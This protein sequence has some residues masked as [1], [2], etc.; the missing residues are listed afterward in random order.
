MIVAY[1]VEC[2]FCHEI[3]SLP[4]DALGRGFPCPACGGMLALVSPVPLVP[5]EMPLSDFPTLS[6]D[7]WR[8]PGVKPARRVELLDPSWRGACRGLLIARGAVE[9]AIPLLVLIASV[10][11]VLLPFVRPNPLMLDSL[12]FQVVSAL[13]LLPLVGH[14]IGQLKC[15]RVTAFRGSHNARRSLEL[16]AVTALVPVGLSFVGP[17]ALVVFALLLLAAFGLWLKYLDRLARR[18]DDDDHSLAGD[19]R[20]FR[21][22]F[23]TY[24]GLSLGL[25]AGAFLAALAGNW[26]VLWVCRAAVGALGLLFLLDY[27]TLLLTVVRAVARRAPVV[28]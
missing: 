24:L 14:A 19:I 1:E 11:L 8:P 3:V 16:L 15:A 21:Y 7:R 9:C 28:P 10:D 25:I 26:T 12:A 20:A 13:L 6:R 4:D 23:L 17:A 27:A 5:A 2:G 22:R 18:I